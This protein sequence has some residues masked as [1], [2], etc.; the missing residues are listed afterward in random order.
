MKKEAG[1]TIPKK[2]P[3]RDWP[4]KYWRSFEGL[5]DD[6]RLPRDPVP[7]PLR[8]DLEKLEVLD[9]TKS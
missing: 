1:A 8:F 3:K 7:P 4:K 2:T 6:F 5:S 9:W